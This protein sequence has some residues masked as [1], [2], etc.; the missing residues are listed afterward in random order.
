[1]KILRDRD[2]RFILYA[3]GE[4]NVK[5]QPRVTILGGYDLYERLKLALEDHYDQTIKD[6]PSIRKTSEKDVFT[7]VCFLND[8]TYELILARCYNY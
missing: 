6:L 5:H 8:T 1:M 3:R 7:V 4:T 2:M